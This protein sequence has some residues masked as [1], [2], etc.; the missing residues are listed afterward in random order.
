[1]SSRLFQ[2]V[3]E[4]RG[5]AYSV[6]SSWNAYR[7]GG[8]EAI[9]AACAPKNLPR[10][11]EVT[12]A[13]LTKLKRKGVRPAELHRAKAILTSGMLLALESTVSRMSSQARQELYFGRVAPPEE[14]RAR[15]EAVTVDELNEEAARVL[16]GRAL[17]LAVVGN[18]GRLPV[19]ASDLAS[20]L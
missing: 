16:D 7:P 19:S 9:Y 15:V 1:M 13:E 8:Y 17:S 3:R 11:L 20:A 14:L 12:L 6:A 4:K 2:E 10:L 18:V 5:L